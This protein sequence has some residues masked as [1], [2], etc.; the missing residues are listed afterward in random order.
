MR[1]SKAHLPFIQNSFIYPFNNGG[2]KRINNKIKLLNRIAYGYRNFSPY[3]KR[4]MVHFKFKTQETKS[5][6]KKTH[7]KTS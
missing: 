6:Q 1:T 3:K 4:I 2:I 7:V 5:E